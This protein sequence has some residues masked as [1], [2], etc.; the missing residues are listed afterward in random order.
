MALVITDGR[1]TTKTK[2]TPLDE[3]SRGIKEKGIIVHVLGVTQDVDVNDLNKMASSKET[4]TT[5]P[6]FKE[7]GNLDLFA[8]IKGDICKSKNF[9]KLQVKNSLHIISLNFEIMKLSV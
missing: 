7:L 8:K 6:S 3:A 4:V 2:F 9:E 5:A 1:Q